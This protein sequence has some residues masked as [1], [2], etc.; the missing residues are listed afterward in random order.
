MVY[1]AKDLK[2]ESGAPITNLLLSCI[3]VLDNFGAWEWNL[4]WVSVGWFLFFGALR[5]GVGK[6]RG[7]EWYSL[8]HA[9]VT[10]IGGVICAYMTFVMAEPM[11]GTPGKCPKFR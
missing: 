7:V 4:R 8:I 9:M 5:Y 11:T 6:T 2:V 1:Y 10:G 3:S